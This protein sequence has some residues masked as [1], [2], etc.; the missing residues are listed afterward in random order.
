[1]RKLAIIMLLIISINTIGIEE[2]QSNDIKACVRKNGHLRIVNDLSECTTNEEAKTFDRSINSD[3]YPKEINEPIRISDQ[4]MLTINKDGTGIG[5]VILSPSGIGSASA[6]V[7]QYNKGTLVLL[8]ASP[9]ENSV[10]AGWKGDG[11]LGDGL[12]VL[13]MS[14]DKTVTATFHETNASAGTVVM[15]NTEESIAPAMNKKETEQHETKE[16]KKQTAEKPTQPQKPSETLYAVQV[17]AFRNASYAKSLK[18]ILAQKG[19]YAYILTS[20]SELEGEFHKVLIGRFSDRADAKNLSKKIFKMEN[21]QTFV[22]S[23][24]TRQKELETKQ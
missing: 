8:T 16:D 7:Q 2:S 20:K 15:R 11:C 23:R 14:S 5:T 6:P 10:F 18:M 1:M 19:Y 24:E 3:L 13:T 21:L 9:D 17:G 22:T 4:Y 12:C